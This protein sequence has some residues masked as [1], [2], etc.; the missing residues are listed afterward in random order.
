MKQKLHRT[1][2]RVSADT[3]ALHYN[4]A[5][6]AMMEYVN[7]LREKGDG[8]R[9]MVEPLVIMLAPY[10]P[11]I[12]EEMWDALGHKES[13]FAARWPAFDEKLTSAGD[14]E[15]AVQVNGK[16]RSRLTV[17]RGMTQDEVMKIVLSDP[18]VQKFVDGQKVKKVI[19]VQ[20]RLVNLVV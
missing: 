7:E 12:A 20:D 11:H 10:A 9:E 6:A 19:Y 3:E 8:S 14:V 1:I 4:T 18:A 15:I 17:A 16:L 5:I 2:Q 13:V